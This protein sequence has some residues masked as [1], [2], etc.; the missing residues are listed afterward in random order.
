[1]TPGTSAKAREGGSGRGQGAGP[2]WPGLEMEGQFPV[3][4]PQETLVGGAKMLSRLRRQLQGI[5]TFFKT[6]QTVHFK[7]VQSI[8]CKLHIK[9]IF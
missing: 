1:M 8:E 9:L 2:Y 4:G 3:K 5:H 7:W 6:H